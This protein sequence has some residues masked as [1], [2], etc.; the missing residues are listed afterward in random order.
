MVKSLPAAA[1]VYLLAALSPVACAQ[2]GPGSPGPDSVAPGVRAEDAGASE[3]DISLPLVPPYEAVLRSLVVPGLGQMRIRQP[4][5]G[6]AF[7][8]VTAGLLGAWWTAYREFRHAYDDE[9]LPA[10]RKYGLRSDEAESLY[11]DANRR[12]KVSR[13]LLFTALGVWGYSLVDAY[14]DANIHNA[15]LRAEKLLQ[16][17][18]EIRRLDVEFRGARPAVRLR[19]PF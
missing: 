4:V 8:T 9:Y 10:V 17:G 3:D 2:D 19:L 7:L 13:F 16:E 12:Y 15:Q 14:V 1:L 6:V 5:Q 18:E 11:G